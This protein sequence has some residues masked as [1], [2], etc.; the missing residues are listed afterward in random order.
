[1]NNIRNRFAHDLKPNDESITSKI[2]NMKIPWLTKKSIEQCDT[3]TIYRMVSW[4]TVSEVKNSLK[5]NR[6]DMFYPDE[7]EYD[8]EKKEYL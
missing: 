4:A 7:T 6:R 1:M 2:N 8:M 3:L 5:Q